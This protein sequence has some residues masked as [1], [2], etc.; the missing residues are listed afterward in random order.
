MNTVRKFSESYPG[1]AWD[2]ACHAHEMA[3]ESAA[4]DLAKMYAHDPA[5]L[6]T[7]ADGCDIEADTVATL[8][9]HIL[10]LR[11]LIS[12]DVQ[13]E[14][15]RAFELALRKDSFVQAGAESEVG[16]LA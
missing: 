1:E 2:D 3:V 14:A 13:A 8:V 4:S 5:R 16:E 10:A 7:D 12:K 6:A 9:G 11:K 15:I